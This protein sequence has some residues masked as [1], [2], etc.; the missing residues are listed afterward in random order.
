MN[1]IMTFLAPCL[2]SAAFF[3]LLFLRYCS[4]PM[5]R[6]ILL[7]ASLLVP[8]FSVYDLSI[9]GYIRGIVGDLSLTT[10]LLLSHALT[11]RYFGWQWLSPQSRDWILYGAAFMGLLLYPL[12][13]G[14]SPYDTYRF[15]YISW[16]LPSLLLALTLLAWFYNRIAAALAIVLSVTAFNVHILESTNLWDYLIDPLLVFYAWG[17]AVKLL[18]QRIWQ[19]IST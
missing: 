10:L 11:S 14:L 13:L 17:F 15:G 4:R 2:L 6:G 9:A 1:A 12:A 19:R 3:S 7:A 8:L 16:L 18:A 5:Q